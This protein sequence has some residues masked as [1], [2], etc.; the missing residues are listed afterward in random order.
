[1]ARSRICSLNGLMVTVF[2]NATINLQSMNADGETW[3]TVATQI[4]DGRLFTM[5]LPPS[6]AG[7]YKYR[8]TFDGDS[9]YVPAVSNTVTLTVTNAASS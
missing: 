3:S 2:P 9:Q 8:V 1:M 7:V 6:A 4:A 5:T